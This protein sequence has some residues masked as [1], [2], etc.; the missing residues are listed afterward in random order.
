MSKFNQ[1]TT[2][3]HRTVNREGG[4]AYTADPLTALYQLVATSLWSGDNFYETHREWHE[5]FRTNVRDAVKKDARFVFNLAAYARSLT[6]LKLRSTPVALWVEAACTPE[7]R[8]TGLA[9]TAAQKVLLRA[10]DPAEAIAYYRSHV[11]PTGQLPNSIDR[12]IEDAL[13]KFDAY[14]LAK[15]KG[16]GNSVTLRDVFRMTSPRPASEEQEQLWGHAVKGTLPTPYTWETELSQKGNTA[17]VWNE[18][19]KSER[20]GIFAIVRNLRNILNVGADLPA[21]LEQI[22]QERVLKSGILPFQWY[23]AYKANQDEPAIMSRIIQ[24][25]EWSLDGI[26]LPGLTAVI[27]DNSASM[28]GASP[29]RGISMRE[30]GNLMG[31]MALK[32]L[33][34]ICTVFGSDAH[35]VQ[36]NAHQS[37]TNIL[38]GINEAG[39]RV[40]G[41][42]YAYKA[43]HLLGEVKVDRVLLFSDMQCYTERVMYG[44]LELKPVWD[45]YVQEVSPE[46]VLYAVNLNSQDNTVQFPRGSASVVELAGWSEDVFRFIQA[47]E[48][49][50]AKVRSLIAGDASR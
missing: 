32:S 23:K 50:D 45:R 26:E 36:V 7:A 13:G 48:T 22:T 10:D 18:L 38:R 42:T 25:L 30:I 15:Y 31:A 12:G 8:G 29:S 27:C 17:E 39:S 16:V 20:L 43:I 2:R 14:Q 6:G 5:R 11:K 3:T 33:G 21:A 49:T 28:D 19:V 24:A 47:I 9:R 37:I 34:G 46:V 4:L 44:V 40:G 41:A 1:P 35:L